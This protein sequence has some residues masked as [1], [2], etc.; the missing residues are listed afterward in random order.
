MI[1][2]CTRTDGVPLPAFLSDTMHKTDLK[3]TS[4]GFIPAAIPHHGKHTPLV[5]LPLRRL[6][7]T[8][9]QPAANSACKHRPIHVAVERSC[10]ARSDVAQQSYFAVER[11]FC[12]WL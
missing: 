5:L 8:S 2:K 10:L 4:Q 11:L 1:P 6:T 9:T 12:A 3:Q 7:Y